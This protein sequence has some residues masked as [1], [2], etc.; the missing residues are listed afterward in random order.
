MS[1]GVHF[2]TC[3]LC[4][5]TC[6]LEV[7]VSGGRVARIR[8][9][10]ADVFSRGFICPKGSTLKHLHEDPDR[11]RVPQIRGATGHR[12][13]GWGEAFAEIERRLTPIIAEHG[14]DSVGVYLGNPNA[15]NLSGLYW[16][17]PLL[18][19]L[20]SRNV[21]TAS[22]VDQ[23]PRHVS[24]GLM[25]GDP[26]AFVVPDLDRTGY[27]L[28]LGANPYESNGSLATAPDW[29]G[30]LEAIRHRGGRIVVVDPRRTRTAAAADEH[31]FIRPGT[32]ALFLCALINVIG[33]EGLVDLG[34]AAPHLRGVDE[35]LAAV[36]DY[37]PEAV[38]SRTGIDADTIR[39]IARELAGADAAAVYGRVGAHTVVA[40]TVASWATDVLNAVTGNLDRPGGAMWGLGAHNRPGRPGGG[41][42]GYR[43]GRW[44]SRVSQRPE[45]NGEFPVG[46]LAEEIE[47]EGPGQIRA[48]I[49]VAGNP[50][51]STPHSSRL[52]A[53]LPGLEFMV[54]VDVYVNETTRH[55]DVILP[56]PSSLEKSH[57]DAGFYGWSLRRIANFSPAVFAGAGPSE[58]DVLGRLTML[59]RGA[60][61]NRD[62]TV[63][64][65][66]LLIGVL[67][68]AVA[69]PHSNVHGRDACELRALV[70][71]ESAAD[72][73]VD[74][75]VRTG[76]WGDGF[77]ADPDGLNLQ[78]LLDNPHGIDFG[79]LEPRL[80]A[81]LRTPSAKVELAP[82]EIL[83]ALPT[84]LA[85]DG[86]AG[87]LALIGRRHLRSNNSWMHNVDVLVKGKERCTL[88][89][90][91]LDAAARDLRTGAIALVQSSTGR[92]EVPVEVSDEV[93]QGVVSLPH[94]WGHDVDGARLSVARWHPGANMNVLVDGGVLD[95]LSGNARMNGMPVSV[96]PQPPYGADRG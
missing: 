19:A 35:A 37:T 82:P 20:G 80:P 12:D 63:V 38:A 73:L 48:L 56:A 32:D 85:D 26:Y 57:Y 39:R 5:A 79:P 75:L 89:I 43:I 50:V 25:Y 24:S 49:T 45:A 72:R 76:P 7:T 74:A 51:L 27:L 86:S 29:P 87:E 77:G 8:G 66:E 40:G 4:E 59:L 22:T 83:D 67:E 10:R 46:V 90:H 95:P 60:G 41:G 9:D 11:L 54:S 34:S 14:P 23:M 61:P 70:Q 33:A 65:E 30:R 88:L 94:G 18:R 71:G 68:H 93:M 64:D 1:D 21:F 47:T 6:G 28:I 16:V 62:P 2:R 15:H 84:V 96:R 78:R 81:N 69:D 92:I 55:A 42:R 17:R 53:A 44:T 3:P 58:S 13:A 52:D 36:A 91:P 31:L